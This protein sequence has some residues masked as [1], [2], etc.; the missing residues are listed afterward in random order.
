MLVLH[1]H[2][3]LLRRARAS[4]RGLAVCA[5]A[6]LIVACTEG[7][8]A[9]PYS[10]TGDQAPSAGCFAVSNGELLLVQGLNGK[11]SPPG[12]SS[13]FDESA[14]CTAYRETW[15]ETGL[16]LRPGDLL[17]TFD[18]GFKLYECDV[19]GDSGEID[20]SSQMEVRDAFYLPLGRFGDF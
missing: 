8:P 1:L 4:F 18:T 5:I 12:G 14:Q 7:K 9:C 10:D 13:K 19:L 11:I 16:R 17:M 3:R 2:A 15:E 6:S 20:P